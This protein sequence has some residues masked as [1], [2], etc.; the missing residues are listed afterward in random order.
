MSALFAGEFRKDIIRSVFVAVV[1]ASL[2][3]SAIAYAA[4]VYFGDT[5]SGLI[6]EYGEYDLVL[7][8]RED[9]A[10][11]ALG[12]MREIVRE[13]FPGTRLKK[14]ITLSGR[15][16]VL[17][18]LPPG[19][20]N[21]E[22][23]EEFPVQFV[24]VPGYSGYGVMIE[25]RIEITGIDS[26]AVRGMLLRRCE[27]VNGVLFAFEHHGNVAV[28]FENASAVDQ[29]TETISKILESYTLIDVRFP[30]S[31]QVDDMRAAEGRLADAIVERFGHR[32]VVTSSELK[33]EGIGD[34]TKALAEMKRF[35]TYYA[36][37][38]EIKGAQR[39]LTAGEHVVLRPEGEKPRSATEQAVD[40]IAMVISEEES[41]YRAVVTQGDVEDGGLYSVYELQGTSGGSWLGQARAN[42]ELARLARSLDSGIEL[43]GGLVDAA[44]ETGQSA[45]VARQLLADY[46]HLIASLT[47]VSQSVQTIESLIDSAGAGLMSGSTSK[48]LVSALKGAK[49][50]VDDFRS[51]L[52]AISAV[53]GTMSSG[54]RFSGGL[55]SVTATLERWQDSLSGYGDGLEAI[56]SVLE[57]S[58]QASEFLSQ[59]S[60]MTQAA[61]EAL[62]GLDIEGLSARLDG[63]ITSLDSILSVDT[64]AI[65]SQLVHIRE[66][67]PGL[68]DE[69]IGRSIRL[70]DS[71]LGGQVIPGDRIQVV[72]SG[73][74]PAGAVKRV[75]ET[76]FE[77][78][79]PAATVSS[80]G[81]IQPGVRTQVL[82]VLGE[83]RSTIAA[84][85]A[86]VL[87][88]LILLF[89]HSCVIS[90]LKKTDASRCVAGGKQVRMAPVY[91]A[92]L[93]AVIFSSIMA[94]SGAAIPFLGSTAV[95]LFGAGIGLCVSLVAEKVSPVDFDEVMAGVAIG[96]PWHRIMRD[97]VIPAGRPGLLSA[98]NRSE[99]S[100]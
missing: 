69:E 79:E 53:A 31:G 52:D 10:D 71:Y 22:A 59:I 39:P 57:D 30:I 45:R 91:S 3:A 28:V 38:I 82:R 27:L 14:G 60:H 77:E 89:D 18:G 24:N 11:A 72:V 88:A 2:L 43:L 32:D 67:L 65:H 66:S 64:D 93:G 46:G 100:F 19:M 58:G 40:T 47:K 61:L 37:M 86:L 94:L 87:T 84:L 54:E 48:E 36:T 81:S 9:L 78:Y 34:L 7:M 56:A 49:V 26:Q 73:K 63:L 62:Y 96:L 68:R 35:L 23:I 83:V 90:L 4:D 33:D 21:A 98:L 13:R 97:I 20:R 55:E 6:G 44:G 92:V 1:V 15:T 51:G 8:V 85:V 95:F 75:V 16:N 17:V 5:V 50:L 80:L 12:Q 74:I 41:G 25:P 42:S 29:A 99:A 70:I 76:L